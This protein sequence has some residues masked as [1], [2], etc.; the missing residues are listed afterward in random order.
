MMDTLSPYE[1]VCGQQINKLK[2]SVSLSGNEHIQAITKIEEITRMEYKKLPIKYLGCPPYEGR[3]NTALFSEMMG[4]ILNRIGGC[5]TKMLSVGE[6]AVL[7]KHVLL[8]LPVH[9]LAAIHPLVGVLNLIKKMLNK[10]FSGGQGSSNWA[11]AKALLFGVNWCIDN[12]YDMII[13]ES[14]SKLLVECVNDLNQ[15]PWRILTEVSNLKVQMENT[16]F[17]LQRCYREANK[18]ANK[19]VSLSFAEPHNQTYKAFVDLPAE[20][21]G[22]MTMDRWSLGNCRLIKKKKRELSWEPP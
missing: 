21:R 19:L 11:E 18:V 17:I 7:I 6:R 2:S 22:L 5:H 8:S 1:R 14:N 10:F 13:A 9:T 3:K 12:G 15:N 20:V 16:S 4:K